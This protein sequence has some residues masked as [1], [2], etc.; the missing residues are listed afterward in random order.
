MGKKQFYLVY[1]WRWWWFT[2]LIVSYC[3]PLY[4]EDLVFSVLFLQI[5]FTLIFAV[6]PHTTFCFLGWHFVSKH[7]LS[8][9]LV[10]EGFNGRNTLLS[11]TGSIAYI[12]TLNQRI[13]SLSIYVYITLS[14]DYLTVGRQNVRLLLT[15][16]GS[17]LS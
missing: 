6:L 2:G 8:M 11:D 15:I 13:Q 9:V 4:N 5:K 12:I 1:W 17:W 7:T 3:S 16:L 10:C 14:V